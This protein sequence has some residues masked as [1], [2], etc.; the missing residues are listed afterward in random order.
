MDTSSESWLM[1]LCSVPFPSPSRIP[2][3]HPVDSVQRTVIGKA[4]DVM[5]GAGRPFQRYGVGGDRGEP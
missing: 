1:S 5:G 2:S 4:V 3:S